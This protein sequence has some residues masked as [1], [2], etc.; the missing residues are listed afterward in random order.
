MYT[1]NYKIKKTCRSIIFMFAV[2]SFTS[3]SKVNAQSIPVFE[4]G[5][6]VCFV[7]DSITHSDHYLRLLRYFYQ[8]RFPEKPITIE[9]CGIS[10][11]SLPSVLSRFDTDIAA[12][13]PSYVVVMMGMN[14]VNRHLY[15]KDDETT[16]INRARAIKA[17]QKN[18][19]V[20]CDRLEAIAVKHVVLMSP[21]IYD[22]YSTN[23]NAKPVIK[24]LNEYGLSAITEVVKTMATSRG[25]GYVPIYEKT[26]E[27]TLQRQAHDPS[28]SL[29]N[30]DRIHPGPTGAYV[31]AATILTSQ[32]QSPIAARTLINYEDASL[33]QSLHTNMTD[34]K[35]MTDQSLE[36]TWIL[37]RLPMLMDGFMKTEQTDCLQKLNQMRM[38]IVNLPENSQW[39]LL[40]QGKVVGTYNAEDLGKG[41]DLAGIKNPPWDQSS[42]AIL[43][44]SYQYS[45]MTIKQ[46]R[47]PLAAQ[48][49]LNITR[50]RWSQKHDTALPEDDVEAMKQ[51]LAE[52]STGY[53][54]ML[55]KNA[56]KFG[57]MQE[58]TLNQ[59]NALQTQAYDH[60]PSVAIAFQ[61][62]PKQ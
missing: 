38:Q 9:N 60:K 37:N 49:F 12:K 30:W 46:L 1:N 39:E 53:V 58:Q 41:V 26:L 44:L 6:K 43:K 21:S 32:Q 13:A 47:D 31:M 40:L 19:S 56:L 5:E 33:S 34:L 18:L 11:D 22:E 2:L 7:G 59:I 4:A 17:F 55:F 57:H 42:R 45:Q 29:I 62:R 15:A 51:V 54:A 24:G 23:A 10:G 8:V 25:L 20:L 61:L 52:S 36:G 50:S 3:L 28:A 16:L 27:V 14:D 35:R 48:K